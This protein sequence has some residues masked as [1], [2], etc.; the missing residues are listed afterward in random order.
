MSINQMFGYAFGAVYLLVGLLGFAVTG[1]VGLAE[2]DGA[3]LLG[4]FEVNPLHNIVHLAI[5]AAF[6]IGARAGLQSS[7]M[8]NMSIGVVYLLVGV[9]GYIIPRDDAVNILALNV[10][11]N[12]LHLVS[13][14]AAVVVAAMADKGANVVGTSY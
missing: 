2:P 13:G 4:L 6:V 11:D 10:A 7:R 5:G 12:W 1:G 8:V 9:V 14:A 3:L